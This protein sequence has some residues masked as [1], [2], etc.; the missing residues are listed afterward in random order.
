MAETT[1]QL[2]MQYR[3]LGLALLELARREEWDAFLEQLALRDEV[4][5]RLTAA[6]GIMPASG[7]MRAIVE[8]ALAANQQLAGLMQGRRQELQALLG[9]VSTQL[10]L[11][12]VYR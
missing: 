9:N 4:Y 2:L 8:E 11:S 3:D 12:S 7:Q 10:K 5:A 6:S 1:E